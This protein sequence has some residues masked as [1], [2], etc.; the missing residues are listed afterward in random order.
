MKTTGILTAAC[1]CFVVISGCSKDPEVAKREY[2]R[3]GDQYVAQKKHKEALIEYRNAIQQD[4]RFGEARLKLAQTYEALGDGRAAFGEFIRAADLLPQDVETQVKAARLLLLA[5]QFE[6]AG[7]RADKAL[8]VAPKNVD[9]LI[10]KGNAAAGLKNL[11]EAL[12]QIDE[13][14][15]LE[16]G[17]SD[18]YCQSRGHRAA[19]GKQAGSRAAFK[20]WRPA[21]PKSVRPVWPSPTLWATGQA[22]EGE[23]ILREAIVLDSSNP[24]TNRAPHPVRGNESAGRSRVALKKVVEVSKDPRDHLLLAD[25]ISCSIG[26]PMP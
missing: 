25:Y 26:V 14:I 3:S 11:D 13:A 24:T 17:R 18:T 4:P 10:V 15:K 12:S 19:R 1:V 5:R 6:D 21:D 8:A 2:V 9:A 20:G 7:A 22:H 16:P 23:E